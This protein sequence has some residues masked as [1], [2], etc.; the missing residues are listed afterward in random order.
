ME[1]EAKG[2]KARGEAEGAKILAMGEATAKAY[3]LQNKAVGSQ[4]VTAIEIAKQIAA[5]NVKV[6]PD[7][8]VQGGES[9]SRRSSQEDAGVPGR[10]RRK[11]KPRQLLND[12][13]WWRP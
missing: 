7:L 11:T 6:T 2:I 13:R 10:K 12:T 4:G 3:E 5:G 8:L 9:S 1:G